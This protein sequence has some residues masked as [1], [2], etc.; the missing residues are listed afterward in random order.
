MHSYAGNNVQGQFIDLAN[1]LEHL[2]TYS[3]QLIFVSGEAMSHQASFV[4]RFLGNQNEHANIVYLDARKKIDLPSFRRRVGQQLSRDKAIDLS[5]PLTES[6]SRLLTTENEFVLVAVTHAEGLSNDILK[7]LW[8]LVLQNRFARHRHHLNVL[9]FGE[10]NWAEG[11]KSWLPANSNSKPVLLSSETVTKSSESPVALSELD[12]LIAS[13]RAEFDKRIAKRNHAYVPLNP[14]KKWWVK[15]LIASV[16]L[17]SFGGIL[18]GQYFDVTKEALAEFSSFL[19]QSDLQETSPQD[20]IMNDTSSAVV[21]QATASDETSDV[22]SSPMLNESPSSIFNLPQGQVTVT[23]WKDAVKALPTVPIDVG[24][25]QPINDASA[26]AET[27][28]DT[29]LE[30]EELVAIDDSP[31]LLGESVGLNLSELTI[32]DERLSSQETA[33]SPAQNESEQSNEALAQTTV[34]KLLSDNTANINLIASA[35]NQSA[36][37]APA[38]QSEE[39]FTQATD[40]VDEIEQQATLVEEQ[41]DARVDYPVDDIV[42]V[43]QLAQL[44]ADS[45]ETQNI[46]IQ[47]NTSKFDNALVKNLDNASFVLQISAMSSEKVLNEYLSDNQLTDRVWVY[48]VERFGGPWHVVLWN[49][50]FSTIEEARNEVSALP[51]SIQA[52]EPFAK[53]VS[54]I[55]PLL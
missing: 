30:V 17:L 49:K 23:E 24:A 41:E 12:E 33:V 52:A 28:V 50:T 29:E 11:A 51:Q 42:S 34:D 25:D 39:D 4:Q 21:D 38:Q 44:T 55:K 2:I 36:T 9:V 14:L 48:Q 6:L 27:R 13:K 26:I 20:V 53:R 47:T 16:F 31:V 45:Q 18:I 5:K 46:D 32:Q 15:L 10:T 22:N 40:T 19:F 8:D 35:D 37:V 3:S 1:R 54:Q 7:E 43:E